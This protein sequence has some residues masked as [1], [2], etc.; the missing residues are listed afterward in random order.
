MI[1][2]VIMFVSIG[3]LARELWR[4]KGLWFAAGLSLVVEVLQLITGRGLCEFD[5]IIHNCLGAAIGIGAAVL[6]KF[7]HRRGT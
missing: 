4:W 7:V 2:N 3:I 1:A 5:D 6:L